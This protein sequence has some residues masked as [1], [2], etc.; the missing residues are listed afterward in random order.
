LDFVTLPRPE[1]GQ[2]ACVSQSD[3]LMTSETRKFPDDRTAPKRRK[4]LSDAEIKEL[5][6]AGGVEGGMEAGSGSPKQGDGKR[7]DPPD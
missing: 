1:H 2:L 7:D 4:K 6:L 3:N 5:E